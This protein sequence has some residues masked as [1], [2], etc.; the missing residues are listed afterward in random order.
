MD[1][2]NKLDYLMKTNG[3]SNRKIL[4]NLCGIPYSTIKHWKERNPD[5]ILFGNIR[6][7]SSF[8]KV[9]LN[10]WDDSDEDIHIVL[11]NHERSLLEAYRKSEHKNAIDDFL[12]LKKSGESTAVVS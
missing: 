4:S 6:I 1:F 12:G 11:T 10:Y 9:P 8:F 3:I 7:L 5:D 2:N